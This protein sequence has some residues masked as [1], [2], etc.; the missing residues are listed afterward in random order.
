MKLKNIRSFSRYLLHLDNPEKYQYK[1][2]DLQ[3]SS[4]EE[5]KKYFNSEITEQIAIIEIIEII[6][7][8]N[9][10]PLKEIVKEIA[11]AGLWS[12]FSTWWDN[13]LEYYK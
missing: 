9:D 2:D 7:N 4:V 3:G 10:K 11:N 12:Y 1:I 6:E 5:I 13:I 8:N